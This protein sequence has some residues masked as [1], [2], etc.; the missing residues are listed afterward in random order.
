MEWKE[1]TLAQK[2][3]MEQFYQYRISKGCEQSFG[4]NYLWSDI[5]RT[6]VGFMADCMVFRTEK[7][8][9]V[10]FPI[11]EKPLQA[12]PLLREYMKEIGE[13]FRMGLV[14]PE[15]FAMLEKAYPGEFQIEYRR[16]EADYIYRTESLMTL[17]GKKLHAK[18]NHINRFR[19]N[20]PDWCFEVITEEN[21][22]ECIEMVKVW[23]E[24]TPG[25]NAEDKREEVDVTIRALREREIIGLDAG[26]L[27]AGGK[28]IAF[29]L[30]EPLGNDTYVVHIEKAF[31]DIQ[32]AYPMINREFASY[33]AKDY[34]YINREED[35]GEEG[36]R[37]AKLSY[38]PEMIYEKGL[39]TL[40][41][42]NK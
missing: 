17:A 42:N 6:K 14:I 27:R 5:Y 32:G 26:L 33:F 7:T 18:R 4:N 35:L 11:G 23:L 31:G 10:S 12:I 41:E 25:G 37:K 1:I 2:Q 34:L 3:V 24:T 40:V 36:L 21:V 22:E 8:K 38:Y 30:G 19:E 16:H 28:V 9:S 20:N 29:S 13:P 15:Q 39:V